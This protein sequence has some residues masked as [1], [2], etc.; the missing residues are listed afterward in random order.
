M[1]QFI[2]SR[3]IL[4]EHLGP[5]CFSFAVM[6]LVFLLD[7][8]FRHLNRLLSKGLPWAVIMEF[9]GLNLAWIIA[10]AVPM[11]VLTATLMA[12]GRLAA[13]NELTALQACGVSLWRQVKPVLVAAALL[14]AGLIWFNDNILPDCN[15]RVRSLAEDIV[16]HKPIVQIEPGVW[17]NEIPHYGLLAQALE[18]SAGQTKA[19][20]LLID[21]NSQAEVRRTISA[22][23]GII[24]SNTAERALSLILF[25]GEIQEIN[26]T[27]GEEFRRISF[28]KHFMTLGGKANLMSKSQAAARTNREKSTQQMWEELRNARN[29]VVRLREQIEQMPKPHNPPGLREA[30]LAEM[31]RL[32][33]L[34]QALLVEIHKKYAIPTACLVFVVIGAPLGALA[35][36]AGIA[37]AT[38]LSLGF[39]L[40]YWA[41]LIGGEVLA[42]RRMASPSFAMWFAN[43]ITAGLGALLFHQVSAGHR[44]LL[45]FKLIAHWR[46]AVAKFSWKRKPRT[47]RRDENAVHAD[48]NPL[49][50]PET[51]APKQPHYMQSNQ[52]AEINREYDA[53]KFDVAEPEF[54]H[55]LRAAPERRRTATQIPLSNSNPLLETLY[56]FIARAHLDLAL[57][58]DRN[59][60]VLANANKPSPNHPQSFDFDK[61]AKLAAAQMTMAQLLGTALH[62][63]D[64]FTC[65]F[66]EGERFQLLVYLI[67]RDFILT[68]LATRNSSLGLIRIYANDAVARLRAILKT[69]LLTF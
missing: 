32:E 28:S 53:I 13:D 44:G 14:A 11:A 33:A 18:D 57:L 39:F 7:L 41:G 29:K 2:L 55:Q 50:Y 10:T 8:L 64:E 40:F 51:K 26:M 6:T 22:R 48:L 66:Q 35:R 24:Q 12:F 63:E 27:K 1:R 19:R 61:L 23:S 47:Y 65:I 5:F 15:L 31:Q 60:F 4:C 25:N 21:D 62:E 54:I 30:K 45:S 58:S 49:K 59:G 42:D 69:R 20:Q 16:R 43:F 56:E 38:G 46:A 67:D 3:H 52:T 37:K 17:Y 68:I 36:S 9:L 34:T